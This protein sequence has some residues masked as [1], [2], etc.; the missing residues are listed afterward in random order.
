M[1]NMEDV[2]D[3]DDGERINLSALM[4]ALIFSASHNNKSRSN[5]G[6]FIIKMR[7]VSPSSCTGEGGCHVLDQT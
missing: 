3:A 4:E 5:S 6:S 7:K 2:E 1:V